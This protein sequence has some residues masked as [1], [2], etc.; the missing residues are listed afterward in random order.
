MPHNRGQGQMAVV[1]GPV[2][3]RG[4]VEARR[5]GGP[6]ESNDRGAC[7]CSC[8]AGIGGGTAAPAAPKPVLGAPPPT[9]LPVARRAAAC[10]SCLTMFWSQSG[11]CFLTMMWSTAFTSRST[12]TGSVLH[13]GELLSEALPHMSIPILPAQHHVTAQSRGASG[14]GGAQAVHSELGAGSGW[15]AQDQKL[16]PTIVEKYEARVTLEPGAHTSVR[17]PPTHLEHQQNQ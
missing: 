3:F 14:L 16:V 13:S 2:A 15:R 6:I 12:P 4:G 5:A 10:S 7:A 1:S 11:C 17:L 9:P 8:A